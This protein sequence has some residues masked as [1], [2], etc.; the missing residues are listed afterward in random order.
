MLDI[1]EWEDAT[2]DPSIVIADGPSVRI[3]AIG[4]SRSR[5]GAVNGASL[6]IKDGPDGTRE[7]VISKVP[8]TVKRL[9]ILGT[10]GYMSL[11]AKRWLADAGISW[12]H[13]ETKG[14]RIRTLGVSGGDVDPKLMRNQA[15]CAT[16][17]PLEETGLAISRRF[18]AEKLEG[19]A[20]NCEAL[21]DNRIA[22]R[23]IR[24]RIEALPAMISVESI[25][26]VEGDA[27]ACY[28][29][30]WH[31]YPIRWQAPRPIKAHWQAF[32][33]RKTL[34]RAW[35]TN[36]D[37]TDPINAVLNY[38]YHIAEVECVLACHAAGLS[39]VM[40]IMH[41]DKAGRDSFA[42]D[43]IEPLRP[44]VDN[45]VLGIFK[46]SMDKRWFSEVRRGS[47][48]GAVE[49]QAPLTHRVVSGVHAMA[50]KL[51]PAVSYAVAALQG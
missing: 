6:V 30:A 50:S 31:G 22:G 26:G 11:E 39:P 35:E 33:D 23:Y 28:W 21:L 44:W 34:L 36:K 18:I 40:G 8:A 9:I 48:D 46:S 41:A 15:M 14:S 25:R 10:H 45:V 29:S 16:G 13:I 1:S 37:A 24:E 38:A 17:L 3:S 19:Q 2:P 42:L 43:L 12:A 51:Q 7:R 27:A 20:W 5:S 49:I 4:G 47:K 32:N